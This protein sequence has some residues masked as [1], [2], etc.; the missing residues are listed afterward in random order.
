M[1]IF[2]TDTLVI[3][4]PW[5]FGKI[6]LRARYGVSVFDEQGLPL[7]SVAERSGPGALSVARM[8]HLSASTPF[9]LAVTRPDGSEVLRV[10]KG[11]TFGAGEVAV[12]APT[13]EAIGSVRY[14]GPR[15]IEFS[16]PDGRS[17]GALD[18]VAALE[19]G[20]L[21][22]RDGDRVRRDVLRL[23]PGTTGALRLLAVGTGLAFDIVRGQG[24]SAGNASP[25]LP[26]L[27]F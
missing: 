7:A 20:A 27:A 5:G 22:K 16:A 19:F 9:R 8:T 12:S 11:F 18:D 15:R 21:A 10:D 1:G 25:R 17:L 2:R 24:T 6:L 23:R 14:R 26:G 4:H 13:G 3:E